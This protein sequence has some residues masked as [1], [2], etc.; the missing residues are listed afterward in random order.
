MDV[1]IIHELQPNRSDRLNRNCRMILE[2]GPESNDNILN[3]QEKK[4][5]F[6]IIESVEELINS[7]ESD[8]I[9][10]SIQTIQEIFEKYGQNSYYLILSRNIIQNFIIYSHTHD[11]FNS[12]QIIDFLID[13]LKNNKTEDLQTLITNDL[14]HY[15]IDTYKV[16]QNNFHAQAIIL[17]LIYDLLKNHPSPLPFYDDTPLFIYFSSIF[18]EF[19]GYIN[20]KIKRKYNLSDISEECQDIYNI[21]ICLIQCFSL[22]IEL[23]TDNNN[24]IQ[25]I[26]DHLLDSATSPCIQVN[27]EAIHALVKCSYNFPDIFF[28]TF[29]HSKKESVL[30]SMLDV[31]NYD[32][33]TNLLILDILARVSFHFDET[34]AFNFIMT[35]NNKIFYSFSSLLSNIHHKEQNNSHDNIEIHNKINIEKYILP[36]SLIVSNLIMKANGTCTSI[37]QSGNNNVII[38][39]LNEYTQELSM[40]L[41]SA[42]LY[43]YLCCL[44]KIDSFLMLEFANKINFLSECVEILDSSNEDFVMAFV[45]SMIRILDD[46]APEE[47]HTSIINII[48]E[49]LQVHQLEHLAEIYGNCNSHIR[50]LIGMI[51]NRLENT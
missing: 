38:Q 7:Q 28:R 49:Q 2:H 8:K 39:I 10:L 26:F 34:S 31:D 21:V 47:L 6:E 27:N 50:K 24:K 43:V 44:V 32:S 1:K 37:Y 13:F 51:N 46:A 15:L 4:D 18:Q 36:I 41:K 17:E 23:S 35:Y 30:V 12:Q 33:I 20:P 29:N 40:K 9:E 11:L 3:I 22:Y 19:S 16:Q 14:F 45:L 42:I 48:V 25:I 5:L